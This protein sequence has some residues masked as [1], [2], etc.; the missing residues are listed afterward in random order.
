MS[1]YAKEEI[2]LTFDIVNQLLNGAMI[3]K[4][5]MSIPDSQHLRMTL[6]PKEP[7]LEIDEKLMRLQFTMESQSIVST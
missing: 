1:S 6:L 5:T 7:P 2:K 4:Q 3:Q